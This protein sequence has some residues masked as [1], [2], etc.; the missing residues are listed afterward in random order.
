MRIL[1]LVLALAIA[2]GFVLPTAYAD[3]K[4]VPV[5]LYH[6]VLESY[7]SSDSIVTI[8][9]ERL[10]EHITALLNAGYTPIS[11]DN[12]IDASKGTYELPEK[13]VIITFDDGY[14]TN[15]TYAYPILKKHGVLAT[16]FVAVESVGKKPGDYPHFTWEQ[17]REMN[18]SGLISIQSHTYTHRDITLLSQFEALREIRY[19][20]YLIEKNLGTKCKVLAF[21]YGFHNPTHIKLA[22]DAGYDLTVKVGNYGKNTP[23]QGQDALVRITVYGSWTGKDLTGRINDYHR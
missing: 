21:P 15:Y 6:N 7:D 13:P 17:A 10:E 1:K 19:S 22:H 23:G 11:F 4:S 9:P 2:V 20:K 14:E 12:Y 5:L 16:I 3:G 18:Q 8:T